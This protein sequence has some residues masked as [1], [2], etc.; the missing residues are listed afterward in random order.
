M[1]IRQIHVCIYIYKRWYI[2]MYT[3]MYINMHT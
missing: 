2:C 3:Y 1:C